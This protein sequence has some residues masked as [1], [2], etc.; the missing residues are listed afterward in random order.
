MTIISCFDV[1]SGINTWKVVQ[2][3]LSHGVH[4][5]PFGY[6]RVYPS[7]PSVDEYVLKGFNSSKCNVVVL[8]WFWIMEI[9]C[10]DYSCNGYIAKTGDHTVVVCINL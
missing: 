6:T 5:K 3:I 2:T 8:V 9:R 1:N 7:L 4:L 10:T